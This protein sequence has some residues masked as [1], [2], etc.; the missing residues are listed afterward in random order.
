MLLFLNVFITDQGLTNFKFDRGLLPS[1]NRIDIFKYSLASLSVIKWTNVIIYYDLDTNYRHLRGE[2]DE[3]I[4]SLFCNPIIYHFRN[5]RQSQWKTAVQNLFALEDDLVWFCC[6]D[7]HIFIDYELDLLE[8]IETKLADLCKSYKFVSCH[9]SHWPEMLYYYSKMYTKINFI[10]ENRDFFV[11]ITRSCES[12]QIVNKNL[13]RDWWFEHDCGDAWMPRTD[14]IIHLNPPDHIFIVPYR[15]LV[16]HF[17]GYS[18][19]YVDI[20]VCPPLFIPDGFFENNIKISYCS[21]TRKKGY[22]HVNPLIKNYSTIKRN[23]ADLKCVLEDLPFFWKSRIAQIEIGRCHS[24]K[25]LIQ[26]RNEAI[27]RI[28]WQRIQLPVN[29]L[30]VSLRFLDSQNSSEELS[31]LKLFRIYYIFGSF[32]LIFIRIFLI[33]WYETI[34]RTTCCTLGSIPYLVKMKQ[35]ITK[36]HVSQLKIRLVIYKLLKREEL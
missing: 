5:D 7:D 1:S 25:E 23:G 30:R 31:R 10:E 6:N 32:P 36:Q 13:L 33:R 11:T 34:Y 14:T 3:Y 4:K 16:R 24:K 27:M 18:H 2:I 15:E 35:K 26:R 12:A 8:R 19:N 28:A 21:D 17:D 22:V 9:F 20:N 29:N